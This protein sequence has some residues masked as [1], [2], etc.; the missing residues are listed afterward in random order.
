MLQNCLRLLAAH[1][2][3][4][5]K[6][7]IDPRPIFDVLKQRFH[8][9]PRPLEDPCAAHLPPDALHNRTLAPSPPDFLVCAP[10]GPCN[11]PATGNWLRSA[12][13][14]YGALRLRLAGGQCPPYGFFARA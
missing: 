5:I 12:R 8:R 11:P 3:E 1:S 2:R 4:P 14:P 7:I 6:K 9:H 13:L 10:P